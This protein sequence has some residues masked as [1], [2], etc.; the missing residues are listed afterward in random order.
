MFIN[1]NLKETVFNYCVQWS[2]V[3]DEEIDC[4]IKASSRRNGF[5]KKECTGGPEQLY[6]VD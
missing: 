4:Y 1:E 2:S 6:A 3:N 5:D